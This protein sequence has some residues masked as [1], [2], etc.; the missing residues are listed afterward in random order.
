MVTVIPGLTTRRTPFF[1]YVFC[2]D[3]LILTKVEY[4]ITH[5]IAHHT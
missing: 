1:G 2:P 4:V 3:D 5:I